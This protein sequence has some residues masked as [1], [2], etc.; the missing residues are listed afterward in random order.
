MTNPATQY[1]AGSG[2]EKWGDLAWVLETENFIFQ[3]KILRTTT[4]ARTQPF[5]LLN[6]NLKQNKLFTAI[7]NHK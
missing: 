4:W 3:G 1:S 6:Q 5:D 7:Q 2:I